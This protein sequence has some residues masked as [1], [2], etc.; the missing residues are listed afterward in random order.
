MEKLR[1][2]ISEKESN[3]AQK[4]DALNE[5]HRKEICSIKE[6]LSNIQEETNL[7]LEKANESL[8]KA[9]AQNKELLKEIETLKQTTEEGSESNNSGD[10]ASGDVALKALENKNTLLQ[11]TNDKLCA[12]KTKLKA[13]LNSCETER[14]ILAE[15][16][17]TSQCEVDSL[18]K[19]GV[20]YR[21][22]IESMG[23]AIGK[24]EEKVKLL[25][26]SSS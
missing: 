24:L 13:E 26:K 21:F 1:A 9:V 5:K 16:V 17:E 12:E 4:M 18:K 6:Q 2:T 10:D 23:T 19:A 14:D 15:R 25:K 20:D 3:H 22:K 7:K 11:Q 8:D